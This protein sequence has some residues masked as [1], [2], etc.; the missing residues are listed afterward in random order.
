[1]IYLFFIGLQILFAGFFLFLC[2]SFVTGGPFVP[3]SKH[4]VEAMIKLADLKAGQTVI[5]IGSGDGRVLFEAAK[6][7][8]RGIGI[9]I[10]PYLVLFT[11]I[12]AFLGPYRGRI[13]VLWKNLW[14]ADLSQADVVFVY[15]IPWRM[16]DLAEKLEDELKDDALVVSNSFVF[17]GWKIVRSDEQHH[18]YVFQI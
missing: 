15:L 1:M 7:G 12:R 14:K 10:N 9:E 13:T 18:V 8:A 3:S 6:E 4:A 5:D 16:E 11:R 17:P 2:L